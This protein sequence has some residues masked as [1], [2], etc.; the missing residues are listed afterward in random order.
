MPWLNSSRLRATAVSAGLVVVVTAGAAY[1]T[2]GGGP[3]VTSACVRHQDQSLY[4]ATRCAPG[5]RSVA[6][7]SKLETGPRGKTG[8]R[9]RAGAA[10]PKGDTGA[11]G[12]KGDTGR[13]G[14]TG[15]TGPPG[16]AGGAG[17]P[18]AP[19]AN[20][21]G[22][23]VTATAAGPLATSS[24]TPTDLGGPAVTVNV[25]AS[26]LVEIFAGESSAGNGGHSQVLLYEDGSPV[27]AVQCDGFTPG[28]IINDDPPSSGPTTDSTTG[29]GANGTTQ[30]CGTDGA[31]VPEAL[32]LHVSPGSHTFK[33]E[34]A[35]NGGAFS[36]TFTN[37]FLSVATRA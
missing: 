8:P 31:G 35:I 10:G 14:P 22:P 27:S 15:N 2:S 1:A 6:L 16:P 5:D 3:R 23:Y 26:G 7:G 29:N 30:F 4:V 34:Y 18:G 21:A 33:L 12:P 24:A 11:A 28:L 19:G 36:T 13:T 17:A 32:T 9:G 25:P 37:S 20:G